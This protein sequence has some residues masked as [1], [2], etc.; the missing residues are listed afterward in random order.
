MR[1]SSE[2]LLSKEE[3]KT[4]LGPPYTLHMLYDEEREKAGEK[5]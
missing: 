1:Y 2:Y 5:K 4:H 3:K